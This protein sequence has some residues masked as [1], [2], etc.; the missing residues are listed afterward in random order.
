[1]RFSR[2]PFK[3]LFMAYTG[4]GH[5]FQLNFIS[6]ARTFFVPEV[7][8]EVAD[9]FGKTGYVIKKFALKKP[10]VDPKTGTAT[11]ADLSEL[12]LQREG[13]DPIVLVFNQ[14]KEGREPV[15]WIAVQGETKSRLVRRQGEFKGSDGKTYKVIDITPKQMILLDETGG[16]QV[17][18]P[19][20]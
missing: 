20:K 2:E 11:G 14:I 10:P 5:D 13:E 15:A 18:V 7:G 8:M 12:T 1:M 17:P 19:L 6:E 16:G 4:D 3:L 9:S